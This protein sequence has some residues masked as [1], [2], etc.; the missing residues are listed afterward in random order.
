VPNEVARSPF[1]HLSDWLEEFRLYRRKNG[2]IVDERDDLM[3]ATRYGHMMLLLA[4]TKPL[5]T[6]R[7]PIN[8]GMIY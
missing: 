5:P 2:R 6:I 3:A 4:R 7:R 8:V 1:D